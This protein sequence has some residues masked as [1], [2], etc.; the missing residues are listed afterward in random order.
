MS[1]VVVQQWLLLVASSLAS[2][3]IL[4][5]SWH[6]WRSCYS[7]EAQ[8]LWHILCLNSC[9]PVL[10][11]LHL[12]LSTFSVAIVDISSI[13][14]WCSSTHH[15]KISKCK[16]IHC[17]F[18]CLHFFLHIPTL[19]FIF[20]GDFVFIGHPRKSLSLNQFQPLESVS[21]VIYCTYYA[22]A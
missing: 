10:P 17:V 16:C 8:V 14:S 1:Y 22:Y 2:I 6:S 21:E 20:K 18:S 13:P 12:F 3:C 4:I 11:L 9:A 15:Q 19:L 7:L 5:Q